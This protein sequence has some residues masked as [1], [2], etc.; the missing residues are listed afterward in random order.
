MTIKSIFRIIAVVGLLCSLKTKGQIN[1]TNNKISVDVST[2]PQNA[3]FNYDSCFALGAKLGMS[4]V[5]IHQPWTA[6]ETAPGTFNFTILDIANWYYPAHGVSIDLNIDPLETN[7]LEVPSDLTSVAFDSVLFINRFKTLLDSV[8]IHIPNSTVFSSLVIGSEGDVYLGSNTVLWQKYTTF[9][10]AVS[11]YARTLWPGIKVSTELTFDGLINDNTSAQVL[12]TNS[13]YIGVSY[14]PLNSNFTVKPVTTV[15]IDFKAITTLYP[16]KPICFYQYGYPSSSSCNSSQVQ[17]AHFITQTFQSWDMYAANIRMIDFTWLH[18]LSTAA[19]NYNATYYGISDLI[20]LE[21]LRTLGL[22]TGDANGT[23]KQAFLE[24]ECQSKQ[25]GYNSLPVACITGIDEAVHE[26]VFSIFPNPATENLIIE[27]SFDLH[28][29]ELKILDALGRTKKCI[30]KINN[31][32]TSIETL[33][34]ADGLYFIELR[35]NH[36]QVNAKFVIK[37]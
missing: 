24:L 37:K 34:L 11:A 36:R 1:P 8:K 25:R 26:N 7:H 28:D 4:S 14:Y 13:D 10:N 30:S 22:R 32:K 12:N 18:D 20:F 35:D 6:I 21:F 15:P 31:R 19:V 5:G 16:T 27:M 17:Q 33:D 3:A 2:Q 9:Y 29:A 23:D